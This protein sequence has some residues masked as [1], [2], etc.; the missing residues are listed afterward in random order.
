MRFV[1]YYITLPWIHCVFL[2]LG[3][4]VPA[5]CLILGGSRDCFRD[6]G[7][8]GCGRSGQVAVLLFPIFHI[9]KHPRGSRLRYLVWSGHC[10]NRRHGV[11]FSRTETGC[12]RDHRDELHRYWR[13]R[14]EP[15]F[16]DG[17]ALTEESLV[18]GVDRHATEVAGVPFPGGIGVPER[19]VDGGEGHAP[20]LRCT[21][22]SLPSKLRDEF[23]ILH[24]EGERLTIWR[25]ESGSVSQTISKPELKPNDSPL[26]C[27]ASS[28]FFRY[29]DWV[30]CATVCAMSPLSFMRA[31]VYV[32]A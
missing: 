13:C 8:R 17:W 30:E 25:S 15:V 4:M 1:I 28:I 11:A 26:R 29:M 20:R 31:R 6:P 27:P 2:G 14:N 12:S 10:A 22:G 7:A 23:R 32:N 3:L 19:F 9:T 18:R 16:E 21:A 5:C 24:R